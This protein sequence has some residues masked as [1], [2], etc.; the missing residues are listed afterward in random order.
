MRRITN[1]EL[2]EVRQK[3]L[4]EQNGYCAL[5]PQK[6]TDPKDICVDHDHTT[7]FIRALLC[8]NCNSMEGKIFNCARRAKRTLTTIVWLQRILDY[9]K[10]HETNQTG[11]LHPTHRTQDEKRIRY[12]KKERKKRAKAKLSKESNN[13]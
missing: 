7:G 2:N 1:K 13:K 11:F 6:F 5:C 4:L 9:W 3:L 8:R 12:N 10:L